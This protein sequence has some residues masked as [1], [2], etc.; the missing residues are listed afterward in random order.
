VDPF[1]VAF[2]T[3]L[4]A[5]VARRYFF[6]PGRRIRRMLGGLAR[7]PIR[8]APDGKVVKV[9]GE[10]AP[11][12]ELLYAPLSGRAC[13][14]YEIL[15]E[16]FHRF[17]LQSWKEV[18]REARAVELELRDESGPATVLLS[19][20]LIAAREF[21]PH[22]TGTLK[23]PSPS[24]VALLE[25]HGQSDEASFGKRTLRFTE[26][27]LEPGRLAVAG[28]AR[29]HITADGTSASYREAPRRLLLRSSEEMP[30]IVAHTK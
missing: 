2:A 21:G 17:A 24:L 9:I 14:H 3:M 8:D 29:W 22:Q 10:V 27:V 23:R 12:G 6:A 26:S 18:V 20:A 15:V 1:A 16:E 11:A 19:G 4:S 30:L 28:L 5:V 7:T 25:R 13:V